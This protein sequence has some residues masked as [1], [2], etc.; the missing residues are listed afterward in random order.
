M[1]RLCVERLQVI[2]THPTLIVSYSPNVQTL[3]S[4]WWSRL[5]I[6]WGQISFLKILRLYTSKFQ[7]AKYFPILRKHQLYNLS[8]SCVLFISNLLMTLADSFMPWNRILR[9]IFRLQPP[10]WDKNCI[11]ASVKLKRAISAAFKN[12]EGFTSTKNW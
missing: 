10:P 4:F 3:Q 12:S 9:T 5:A 2:R 1:K 6:F 7:A 8:N 11:N